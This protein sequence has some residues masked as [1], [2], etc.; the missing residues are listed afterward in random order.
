M[1]SNN[2]QFL[3]TCTQWVLD[4]LDFGISI[5]IFDPKIF[6][7]YV[8]TFKL[9]TRYRVRSNGFVFNKKNIKS[10]SKDALT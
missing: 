6:G 7:A 3:N 9:K 10:I 2:N 5:P 4:N 8:S 1:F